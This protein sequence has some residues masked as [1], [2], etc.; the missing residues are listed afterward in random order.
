MKKLITLLLSVMLAFATCLGLVA[1]N[2][3]GDGDGDAGQTIDGKMPAYVSSSFSRFDNVE[4]DSNFKLGVICLHDQNSTYDQNFLEAVEKARVAMKLSQEQ[5][6][7]KTMIGEDESCTAAAEALVSQGCQ[8]IFANSFGH[9]DYLKVA[10]AEHPEVQFYH[11]TGTQSQTL[12]LNNFHNAFATIFEGRY[13]AGVAAGL[14]LQ[15]MVEAGEIKAN[16]KDAAG[17]IKLGYIGAHPYAEV[18][19]GYT[20]WFLGVRSIVPNVVMDVQ[21]TFTWYDETLEMNA[22][23]A[24]IERGCALISQHADS[25]G[26]PN[27]CE[28]AGVPN[29]SYNGSTIDECPETFIISSK[30]DWTYYFKWIIASVG[31][32]AEDVATDFAGTI[33]EG[34]MVVLTDA[35]PNVIT[36]N[37][38]STLVSVR[39]ELVAGT[40]KV[41]DCSKFTVTVDQNKKDAFGGVINGCATVDGS[42][43]N[44]ETVK[45]GHL[46]AYLADVI[47]DEF[48]TGDTNVV[49]TDAN[50][51]TYFAES[52]S[53]FRS[54]PFFNI[55]IDGITPLN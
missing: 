16:N 5:V 13:L 11:A 9:E 36:E 22:A 8:A 2:G 35:N 42:V 19:S 18:I 26:A 44:T 29:V 12:G 7:I 33:G 49:K 4:I 14:K 27:A 43:Q 45:Q 38:I 40:R 51:V 32:D 50:G 46:T 17:N 6:I 10:A 25:W 20:S 24:L 52:A 31:G 34:L 47:P 48:F 55:I 53:E 30:I 41:F 54:A 28:E 3:D 23:N 37:T 39:N 15:A 1:C 21:Y